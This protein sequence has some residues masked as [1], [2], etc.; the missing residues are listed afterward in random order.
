M[1]QLY[2]APRYYK[3]FLGNP[4]G[5][6]SYSL[7]VRNVNDMLSANFICSLRIDTYLGVNYSG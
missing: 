2:E 3:A 5:F 1:Y 6:H 4:L 7:N